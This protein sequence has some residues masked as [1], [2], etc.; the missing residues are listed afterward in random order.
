MGQNKS[1]QNKRKKKLIERYERLFRICSDESQCRRV[2]TRAARYAS[3][4][5]EQIGWL[6]RPSH[7]EWCR[8]RLQLERHHFDYGNPLIVIYVCEDCHAV[9][10]SQL[11]D[12]PLADFVGAA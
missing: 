11:Q 6:T 9:A 10:D 1:P 8:R 2:R 4:L 12:V 3:A 7:C 5:A